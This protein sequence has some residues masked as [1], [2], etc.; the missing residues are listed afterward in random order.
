MAAATDPGEIMRRTSN[1]EVT[2]EEYEEI[3]DEIE[4]QPRWR[5]RADKEMDYAD[6]NQLDNE[7]L[8][9]Q[10][11][12]GIPP[13][14]EDLI[15]PALLS[16]Q[17]YEAE[18]RTDWR[19]TPNGDQGADEI[20]KAIGYKL[21]EAESESRA[22][23][24]CSDAFRSQ[25]GCGLGW[26]E[27]ARSADPFQFPYR[28]RAVHRNEIHWDMT[29][30]EPD[31]S[32]A[33][34]LRRQRWLSPERI[35]LVFPQHRDLILAA[36]RHG[37]Q[38]WA[39]ETLIFEGGDS[40]GLQNAWADGRSWTMLED[41]WYNP[42]RRELCVS[43]L[44]YRRWER[45]AVIKTP[46][47]RVVEYD[48]N[49]MQHA[50][51]VGS[52]SAKVQI[53]T[54]PRVRM[55]YW[56]GPY[57]LHDAPSP[58]AHTHFPYVPFF[59]FREDATGT[60]Y[61]YVRGMKYAQDS[62]NSGLSKLRWGLASVRVE[63]TKGAVAMTDAQLRRQVARPDAD[64]VLD[65]AHMAQPGSKFEIF[66]DFQL[67]N[68]HFQLLGDN[69]NT[70]ER[71]SNITKGFQ[72]Q[73]GTATSGKQ[74]EIQR[75]QSNQS[76]A[77][78]MDNFK[79]ART[80]VGE[81]LVSMIIR[82]IGDN[83]MDV[84]VEGNAISPD[85][86]I[87]LNK[88]ELDPR[89]GRMYLSNDIQKT[90]L[91]VA[92]QDVPETSSYREQQLRALTE[93][94]KPLPPEYLA[95]AVPFLTQLMDLPFKR[96]LSDVFRSVREQPTPEQIQQQI[97]EATQQAL[98]DAAHDIK[99]QELAIKQQRAESEIKNLDAKAVQIGVQAAFSAM[100]GAAQ[101]AQMPMIAPIADE[102][103]KG[104][105][106]KRPSPMGDDPN[107][108]V[109]AETAARQIRSP[110]IEG[111]GAQIGSEQLPIAQVQ[112]NTSPAFPPVPQEPSAGMR[113]IETPATG[114]NLP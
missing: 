100:Q 44:W 36:G 35:A 17:G 20:A 34:W 105:G 109:A 39:E 75:E 32:D 33:R 69:R 85:M 13:A 65:A 26:V 95:A 71:V 54:V 7:L 52:G 10:S 103:M 41:R 4:H 40:T 45:A 89:T 83:P 104:A 108:P 62:L 29:A 63:R 47:G 21:K 18:T 43:E 58:Y 88:P 79:A 106:Y 73:T 23:R 113:G 9:R 110:Y 74:E 46:N 86:L 77:R 42:E 2:R 107:F 56:L 22:D 66:R 98:K 50:V 11:E 59:G 55:A 68:Q 30:T 5:A 93:A 53:A 82:D 97:D 15:G 61:G 94:I 19:V 64:I 51:A 6:G 114:D 99:Q 92:L 80:Q 37:A 27:V 81:L 70:I 96:E 12:L 112:Q 24:A 72:G 28:C 84:L 60:P 57:K 25:I 1:S 101:I 3:F 49:N 16:I 90:R 8:A 87:Q 102:V 14:V 91:K 76:L 31:L 111:Q 67:S 38:W 78:M 48:A